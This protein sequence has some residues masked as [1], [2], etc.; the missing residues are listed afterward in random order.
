[1]QKILSI[2]LSFAILFSLVVPSVF[3]QE[4]KLTLQIVEESVF[5]DG[6]FKLNVSLENI[7]NQ[8]GR[9]HV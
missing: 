6:D 5:E 7:S 3:A 8:I 4:T 2:C 1:M 9:A